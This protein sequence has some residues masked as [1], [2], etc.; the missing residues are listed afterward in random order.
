MGAN[1][2]WGEDDAGVWET[3]CGH[4]FEFIDG[5][6]DENGFSFC[7]YCGKRLEQHALVEDIGE[8]E[9]P[10]DGNY[11]TERHYPISKQR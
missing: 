1:C 11:T 3:D 5:G 8:E 2:N 9:G 6:P 7:P 4:S 10:V